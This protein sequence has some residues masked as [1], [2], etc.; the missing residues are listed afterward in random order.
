MGLLP[1]GVQLHFRW[2]HAEASVVRGSGPQDRRQQP[3]RRGRRRQGQSLRQRL[4]EPAHRPQGRGHRCDHDLGPARHPRR[5]HVAELPVGGG[6]PTGDGSR[7]RRQ[8]REPRDQ[9][10]QQHRQPAVVRLGFTQLPAR[11]FHLPAGPGL[12]PRRHLV[13]RGLGQQPGA[14]VP[15]QRR[16]QDGDGPEG[17]RQRR[18]RRGPVRDADR[19]LRRRRRHRLRRR[20]PQQP[21]PGLPQRF[22]VGGS[23]LGD[24]GLPGAVG[25][26]RR[27]RR[28]AL[29]RRHR[30]Q[31]PGQDEHLRRLRLRGHRRLGGYHRLRRPLPGHLRQRLDRLYVRHLGQPGHQAL[32][33]LTRGVGHVT[34]ASRGLSNQHTLLG[35]LIWLAS[36]E[37][38]CAPAGFELSTARRPE[39][40]RAGRRPT[41]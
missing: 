19:H 40:G 13:G 25:R 31:A 28:L 7:L 11:Q 20:H 18:H 6:G 17:S 2:C 37:S 35:L 16:Q 4:V 29:G 36:A 33:E 32:G 39:T 38:L 3:A 1:Q 14:T 12:R 9:G 5:S 26:H 34:S 23:R 8:P 30:Q 10:L 22:V 27:P 21:D 15:R 41:R 24:P